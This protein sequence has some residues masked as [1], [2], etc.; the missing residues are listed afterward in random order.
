[1]TFCLGIKVKQ[2][3][4]ALSDTRITSG[5]EASTAKKVFVHEEE[6][7]SIFVMTS[8]LRSVRDKA[9]TYFTE[10]IEENWKDL[11]KMYKA[12]NGFGEMLRKVSSEDRLHLHAGGLHFNLHTI[13]GGQMK[14]DSEPKLYL[15]YPEGNWIEILEGHPF[16]IIGNSGYGKPILNRTITY[17]SSLK[18]CLKAGFLS[19]DSTRVSANDVDFPID[20]LV[21]ESNSFA[22][23]QKRYES[24]DLVEISSNWDIALKNA[25]SSLSN[26]WMED[27]IKD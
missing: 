4:F 22:L 16:V 7:G 26:E 24:D 18:Q 3:L 11:N 5:T 15:I 14:G 19:F 17:N 10:Y 20:V 6:G 27:F 13:I 12:V 21:Y 23:K 9:M 1:M 2:G 25:L 8:G